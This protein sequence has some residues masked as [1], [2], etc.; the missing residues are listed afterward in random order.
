MSEYYS[1]IKSRGVADLAAAFTGA[2]G[3]E[4]K[5]QLA[6]QESDRNY[7]LAVRKDARDALTLNDALRTSEDNLLTAQVNRNLVN[8]QIEESDSR[9]NLVNDQRAV[10]RE[11]LRSQSLVT[12]KNQ[13][14]LDTAQRQNV[15]DTANGVQN[16]LMML[17]V[18]D[19]DYNGGGNGRSYLNNEAIATTLNAI[20]E[21]DNIEGQVQK[22]SV[23]AGLLTLFNQ[24]ASVSKE[25]RWTDMDQV[26]VVRAA[27]GEEVF[28]GLY[29]QPETDKALLSFQKQAGV[30]IGTEYTISGQNEA[31][32]KI[33][34]TDQGGS[35]AQEDITSMQQCSDFRW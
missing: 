14:I 29:G 33:Y 12:D 30:T 6:R 28:S 11:Q 16:K 20:I 22:K 35:S 5:V 31:G 7:E 19:P 8:Q 9:I 18:T 26:V 32:E 21:P 4:A 17:N 15:I 24:M 3:I 34:L 25:N 13:L 1:N 10:A 23:K 2:Y 27:N